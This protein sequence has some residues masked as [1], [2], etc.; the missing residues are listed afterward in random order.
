MKMKQTQNWYSRLS[1]YSAFYRSTYTNTSDSYTRKIWQL[2]ITANYA[3]QVEDN[4]IRKMYLKR[5][6][7]S[8]RYPY[9]GAG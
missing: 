8:R 6:L 4:R 9:E 3:K 5:Y 1:W 7:T 2:H